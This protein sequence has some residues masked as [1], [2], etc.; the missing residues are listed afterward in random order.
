M[1]LTL[2]PRQLS[3]GRPVHAYIMFH[4]QDRRY[5]EAL[6]RHLAGLVRSGLIRLWDC[7]HVEPGS[8]VNDVAARERAQADLVLVLVTPRLLD[9]DSLLEE[10][11]TMQEIGQARV[12]PI[13]VQPADWQSSPLARLPPLPGPGHFIATARSVDRAWLKVAQQIKRELLLAA[14]TA[15]QPRWVVLR[16][17]LQVLEPHRRFLLPSALLLL[18]AG[19]YVIGDRVLAAR[20]QLL[21]IADVNLE[22]PAY[23]PLWIGVQA[24]PGL[25]GRITSVMGGGCPERLAA[26]VALTLVAVPLCLRARAR[27]ATLLALA[28]PSL[29]GAVAL[30]VVVSV[31]HVFLASEGDNPAVPALGKSRLGDAQYEVA[32]W[33]SND[34]PQNDRRRAALGGVYALA[35]TALGTLTVISLAQAAPFAHGRPSALIGAAMYALATLVMLTGVPRAYAL[36]RWGGVYPTVEE[37]DPACDSALATALQQGACLLWD[38]S[39]GATSQVVMV[40]GARCPL[41]KGVNSFRVLRPPTGRATCIVRWG[42]G[43][44]VFA[45]E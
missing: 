34:T 42:T 13:L 38:V 32:S 5:K 2:P 16:L 19:L 3:S 11:K 6:A 35:L 25:M 29:A 15:D 22:Y 44:V 45:K 14:I 43:E 8:P 20:A 23:L 31:S 36:A 12:A 7:S 4:D 33:V 37:L 30:L 17:F 18:L 28:L 24:L 39:A 26:L 1:S 21:G 27:T 10:I 41:L 40:S 9:D